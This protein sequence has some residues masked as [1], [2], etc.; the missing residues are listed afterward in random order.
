[1]KKIIESCSS[2]QWVLSLR[3]DSDVPPRYQANRPGRLNE[4]WKSSPWSLGEDIFDKHSL[5]KLELTQL[6]AYQYYPTTLS[7]GNGTRKA[8]KRRNKSRDV[9]IISIR[10][11][12]FHLA[13][14]KLL[15]WRKR[16]DGVTFPKLFNEKL[17]FFSSM[18]N[19]D[20]SISS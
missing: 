20:V 4:R 15:H 6:P 11:E 8:R 14:W 13:K 5:L 16:H 10:G 17:I 1:M 7:S 2:K 18:K 19:L 3:S 9:G 12:W